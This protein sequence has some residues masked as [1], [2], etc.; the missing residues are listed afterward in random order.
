MPVQINITACDNELLVL[1]FQGNFSFELCRIVSGNS[2]N[3]NVTL[4]IQSGGFLGSSF[5]NGL[6]QPLNQQ[7][8]Q[9]IPSGSYTL[10]LLGIN[11]GGPQAFKVTVGGQ[12]MN[13]TQTNSVL[14]TPGPI[15]IQV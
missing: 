5:L 2:Q 11:W 4:N 9:Y 10:L 15:S 8:F 14:Y 13:F 6:L 12:A 7:I 3:V 1:A